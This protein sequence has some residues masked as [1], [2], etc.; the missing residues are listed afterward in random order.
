MTIALGTVPGFSDLQATPLASGKPAIGAHLQRINSNANFGLVRLEFFTGIYAHGDTVPLP[1]SD[2]D[3]YTYARSELTYIW[4]PQSTANQATGW[5]SF[6]EPW[7]MWY[8]IWNVDQNTGEVT[9]EIGYR[10]ND[11]H[12]E[13]QATTNDG[14]LQVFTVAQRQKNNLVLKSQPTFTRKVDADFYVGEA[15]HTGLMTALNSD[16]KFGV[17]NTEVIYMGVFAHGATV[18]QPVSPADGRT[19]AYSEVMFVTAWRWTGD[20]DGRTGTRL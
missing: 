15:L 4:V 10:G 14:V 13:R 2:I 20:T 18:P 6:R 8:G 1:T 7:T 19:Y 17:V 9:S 5:A 12:K 11:D 16:A 3:G